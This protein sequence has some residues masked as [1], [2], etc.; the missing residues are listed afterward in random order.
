MCHRADM[1][2][3]RLLEYRMNIR[4]RG[5]I[6]RVT[7]TRPSPL[8][9]PPGNTLDFSYPRWRYRAAVMV[10]LLPHPRTNGISCRPPISAH[11]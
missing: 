9:L 8:R 5:A 2:K 10:S 3:R 11:Q 1:L 7:L 6:A 4:E